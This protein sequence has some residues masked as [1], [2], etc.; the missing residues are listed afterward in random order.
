MYLQP[1]SRKIKAH[2]QVEN[3]NECGK[4]RYSHRRFYENGMI[5]TEPIK[6]GELQRY[7]LRRETS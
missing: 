1:P 2:M 3:Y 4:F 6:V 5:G 7:D